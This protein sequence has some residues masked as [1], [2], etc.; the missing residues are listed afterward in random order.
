ME[1]KSFHSEKTFNVIF[2]R[3]PIEIIGNGAVRNIKLGVNI[4][5]GKE[6]ESQEAVVTT[7]KIE[8]P[9]QLL[10]RSIGIY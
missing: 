7:E 5:K 8:I 4:L 10:L 6:F 3:T 1:S 2:K 9:C